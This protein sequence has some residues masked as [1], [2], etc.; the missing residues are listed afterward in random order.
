MS[1]SADFTAC[2]RRHVIPLLKREITTAASQLSLDLASWTEAQDCVLTVARRHGALHLE[3]RRFDGLVDW[4]ACRLL[5]ELIAAEG[6]VETAKR[7]LAERERAEPIAYYDWLA[8]GSRT[9]SIMKW[10]FAGVDLTYRRHVLAEVRRY[11]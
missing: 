9:P 6:R 10:I 3:E 8:D 2:F 11:V 7:T 1:A 5:E 4:V